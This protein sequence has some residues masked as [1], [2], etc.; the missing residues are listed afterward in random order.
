MATNTLAPYFQFMTV[1]N[2]MD[3]TDQSLGSSEPSTPTGNELDLSAAEGRARQAFGLTR[4]P[5]GIEHRSTAQI[6]RAQLAGRSAEDRQR[7]HFVRNGEV[8]VVYLPG[9]APSAESATRAAN[10]LAA[11]ETALASERQARQLAERTL[12]GV[13]SALHEAQTRLGHANLA[14]AEA[15]EALQ[16]S[17]AEN[18]ELKAQ[19]ECARTALQKSE[20][21]RQ[22]AVAGGRARSHPPRADGAGRDVKGDA[23]KPVRWW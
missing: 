10:R 5:E 7:T 8:P 20:A 13:Q 9:T 23:P 6:T 22:P 4:G 15:D 19:L 2:I 18:A 12:A 14:H 17:L 11:A 21:A 1:D 3:S 16:K